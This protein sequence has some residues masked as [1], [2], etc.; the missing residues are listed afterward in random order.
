MWGNNRL[1]IRIIIK[2]III[3]RKISLFRK[4]KIREIIK[5]IRKIIIRVRIITITSDVRNI[6]WWYILRLIIIV[7]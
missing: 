3:V 1:R 5:N 7:R 2:N 4:N 6:G